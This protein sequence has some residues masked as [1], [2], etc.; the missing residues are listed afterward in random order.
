[1]SGFTIS[2]HPV[3]QRPEMP[4]NRT[5]LNEMSGFRIAGCLCHNF[6]QRTGGSA[7]RCERIVGKSEHHRRRAMRR[8][9]GALAV[10]IVAA[11]VGNTVAKADPLAEIKKK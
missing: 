4:G 11:L 9:I 2:R 6:G 10:G 8:L 3:H 5:R 1:M 7:A